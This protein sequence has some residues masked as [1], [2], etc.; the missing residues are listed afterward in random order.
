MDAQAIPVVFPRVVKAAVW[1]EK[2]CY[3][4]GQLC[5]GRRRHRAQVPTAGFFSASPAFTPSQARK[6]QPR[7]AIIAM[8]S[9]YSEINKLPLVKE[10][11]TNINIQD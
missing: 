2:A 6:Q 3:R 8:Q 1:L 9:Q 4:K 7:K 5:S 10:H 11:V